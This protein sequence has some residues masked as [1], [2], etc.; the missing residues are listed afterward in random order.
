[1][2]YCPVAAAEVIVATLRIKRNLIRVLV[3]CF[4]CEKE[5]QLNMSSFFLSHKTRDPN[6][7]RFWYHKNHDCMWR[8][9]MRTTGNRNCPWVS[10]SLFRIRFMAP[11]ILSFGPGI[12][13]EVCRTSKLVRPGENGEQGTALLPYGHYSVSRVSKITS[14]LLL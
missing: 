1:M 10:V 2:Y 3:S 6:P 5:K 14:N 12:H 13:L 9:R 7:N 4:V 11:V 8:L